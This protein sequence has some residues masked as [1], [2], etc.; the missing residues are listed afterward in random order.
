VPSVVVDNDDGTYS[1]TY[2]ATESGRYLVSL[3]LNDDVVCDSPFE[4]VVYPGNS[5]VG[6]LY[7]PLKVLQALAIPTWYVLPH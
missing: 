6:I 4:A 7:L 2:N 1:F 3:S 5:A